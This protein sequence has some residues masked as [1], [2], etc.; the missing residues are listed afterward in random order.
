[1]DGAPPGDPARSLPLL[2][3]GHGSGGDAADRPGRRA[4]LDLD[5]VVTAAVAMADADGLAAL[6]M[7][8]L[9]A[10][11]GVATMTL[12][13]HVPG[14]GELVDLML[15]AVLGELYPE[16][17]AVTSGPWRARLRTV[18]HANRD[19]YRRHPWAL[20]AGTRPAPP[21]P[22]RLRKYELELRTVDGLGLDELQMHLLVSTLDGF[23]RG[24]AGGPG[25]GAT[26]PTD[27]SPTAAYADRVL[28]A[29]PTA[30]RVA[31]AGAVVGADPTA[32]F[33]FGLE[34]LLDGIGVLVLEASR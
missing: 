20:L 6:T 16:E 5:R 26:D 10:E 19:L 7:R 18:A 25:Q 12:Y 29:F 34:R 21:G 8:R 13:G 30:A 22:G 24:A 14:R 15:D 2:W 17:T 3:R 4:T 11:L 9:A 31:A 27:V 1:M 33:E 23:V 28:D 32:S